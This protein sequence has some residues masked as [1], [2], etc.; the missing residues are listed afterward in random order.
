MKISDSKKGLRLFKIDWS[1]IRLL[2]VLYR[3]KENGYEYKLGDK[4]IMWFEKKTKSSLCFIGLYKI[5]K[6]GDSLIHRLA[7]PLDLK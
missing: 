1:Y 3:L 7:L 5:L 6:R 2:K 4:K